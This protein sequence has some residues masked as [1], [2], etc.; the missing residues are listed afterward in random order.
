[1]IRHPDA[2][3]AWWEDTVPRDG[4]PGDRAARAQLRRCS[5]IAEALQLPVTMHLFRRCGADHEL[6][7]PA[8]ALCA[9][10]LAYVREHGGDLAVARAV[11]PEDPDRPETALLKPLR[12][13]RLLDATEADDALPAFRRLVALADGRVNVRDLARALL[14]WTNPLRGEA[15]RR[16]WVFAYWNANPAANPGAQNRDTAA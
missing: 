1:M 9:A 5:T 2:A 11:G 4:K 16:R 13:R 10:T 7:L 6:D 14:D 3:F 15:T 12:F 8:V